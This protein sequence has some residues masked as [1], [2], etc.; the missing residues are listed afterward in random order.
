MARQIK[1][2]S[3]LR[4]RTSEPKAEQSKKVSTPGNGL[5]GKSKHNLSPFQR[6]KNGAGECFLAADAIPVKHTVN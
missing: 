3:Q 5:V 6:V 4:F 1:L 2:K